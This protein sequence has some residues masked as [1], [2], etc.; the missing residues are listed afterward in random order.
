MARK[1]V[2][3]EGAQADFKAIKGYVKGKFGKDVWKAANKEFKSTTK[4][5]AT[6]PESGVQLEELAQ[7]GFSN[8]RKI[9]VRQ[10]W[11]VYEYD[12][13]FLIVYMFIHTKRDFRT[14]LINR[15]LG[16]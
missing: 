9:L 16:T 2:I 8:F 12:D 4:R 5:A 6:H 11:I 10:T 13:D 3:L 15:M 14:H 7:F 1:A